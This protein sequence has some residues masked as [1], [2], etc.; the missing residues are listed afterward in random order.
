MMN[1]V[2]MV[3]A[4]IR[5]KKGILLHMKTIYFSHYIMSQQSKTVQGMFALRK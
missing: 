2:S 4:K 1:K 3:M 5:Y